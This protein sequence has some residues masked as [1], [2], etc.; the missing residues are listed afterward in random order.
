MAAMSQSGQK[1]AGA[2]QR[3]P[4]GGRRGSEE[5][6]L[7]LRV[8]LVAPPPGV[9]F[10]LQG[11]PGERFD[12]QCSTGTDISFDFDVRVAP[13]KTPGSPSFL[14]TFTQGPPAAR[15]VYICS[16]TLAGQSTSGWTRR[17]KVPLGGITSELITKVRKAPSARLEARIRGTAGDGG[18][19]C[20]TVPLLDAG[21]RL[22]V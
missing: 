14:G 9:E 21:W 11:G 1:Q 12:Q 19:A 18:P 4:A 13:G 8:T 20:A 22:S 7:P 10:C 15:F 3:A 5:M 2:D 6:Q 16:G 17:A